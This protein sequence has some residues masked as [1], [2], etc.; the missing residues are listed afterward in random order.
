MCTFLRVKPSV[1]SVLRSLQESP[2][3]TFP[4]ASWSPGLEMLRAF[5]TILLPWADEETEDGEGLPQ[6]S[7]VKWASK[8][9]FLGRAGLHVQDLGQ[10]TPSL[11]GDSSKVLGQRNLSPSITNPET[12]S[13]LIREGW[14]FSEFPPRRLHLEGCL[15]PTPGRGLCAVRRKLGWGWANNTHQADRSRSLVFYPEA[16]WSE[17]AEPT[18]H[19]LPAWG[20][21]G[22]Q[23]NEIFLVLP[24]GRVYHQPTEINIRH[25]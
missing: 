19:Q 6:K 1:P 13:E 14:A 22:G 16:F 24:G 23:V 17:P 25:L 12:A 11:T 21:G 20:G 3:A 9:W 18:L 4:H 15:C 8:P 7:L 5:S 10:R 2:C